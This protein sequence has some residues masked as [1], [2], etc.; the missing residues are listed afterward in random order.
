MKK[1]RWQFINKSV[2]GASHERKGV[3]CQDYSLCV[4][5]EG[6]NTPVVL[7]VSDGHGGSRYVRSAQGAV[8]AC[9]AALEVMEG[10]ANAV[11]SEAEPNIIRQLVESRVK[12]DIV[13]GWRSRVMKHAS[14]NPL[15]NDELSLL[16][17]DADECERALSSREIAECE[18]VFAAYGTT[19]LVAVIVENALITL[20]IGDGDILF[21]SKRGGVTEPV[22]ADSRLLG[23]ETTSLCSLNAPFYIRHN[24]AFSYG[25]ESVPD[26]IML[27]SDG[28]G[29][30]FS[31]A[32]DYHSA[33][34]DFYDLLH[35]EGSR[36][37]EQNI[38]E[39]LA[40]TSAKGSGDDI[41]LVVAWRE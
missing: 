35:G 9:E 2:R 26:L 30:S 16:G 8:F 11:F 33:A 27:A 25:R 34:K 19:L 5:G 12:L 10:Y 20:Q 24:V 15:S 37:V 21:Y 29:N 7:A 31:S 38:E 17:I 13:K 4:S 39:W 23:N 1:N 32:A 14:D 28:Y 3:P 40:E 41:T 6:G 36:Y 18:N 22:P